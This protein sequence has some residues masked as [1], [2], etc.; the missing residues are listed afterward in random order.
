MAKTKKEIEE[1]LKAMDK[2]ELKAKL[3][4]LE[5][6]LR[7]LKFATEGSKSKNVKEGMSLRRQIAR[8]LTEV[9]KK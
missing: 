7:A 9:N 8:V 6:K 2:G 5:E 1:N 4:S 3:S